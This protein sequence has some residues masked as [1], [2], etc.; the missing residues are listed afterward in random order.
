MSRVAGAGDKESILHYAFIG[1]CIA[2][3]SSLFQGILFFIDLRIK[4]KQ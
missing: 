1:L 2:S 3:A 4:K